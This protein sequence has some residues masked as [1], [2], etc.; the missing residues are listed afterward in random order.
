MTEPSRN[1]RSSGQIAIGGVVISAWWDANGL[2]VQVN[3][4]DVDD[5]LLVDGEVP[6]DIAIGD[7]IIFPQT[8][9]DSWNDE[10]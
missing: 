2:H 8:D 5:S 9:D 10:L 1:P 7:T 6:L 4:D 3:L